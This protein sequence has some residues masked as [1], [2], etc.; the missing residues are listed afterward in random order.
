MQ[1]GPLLLVP[2]T[3]I[4]TV[5]AT[6]LARLRP[7]KIIVLG[8][9]ASVSEDV[10]NQLRGYTSGWVYRFGG[11]DRYATAAAISLNTYAP[12]VPVVYIATGLGFADALAGA[13]AAGMENG[14]LLLVPG[15]SIPGVV[16]AELGRL[17]PTRIIVLGGP[18]VVSEAVRSQAGLYVAA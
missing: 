10:V 4:P 12:G 1:N 9:P 15:T 16:A 14:P 6:E 2:N 17:K 18:S 13:P 8:G 3:S 7:A 5:I 11:A